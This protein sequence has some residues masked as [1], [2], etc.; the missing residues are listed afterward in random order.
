MI[1][2][3]KT[4]NLLCAC[5]C[6]SMSMRVYAF[7]NNRIGKFIE[8]VVAYLL[9]HFVGSLIVAFCEIPSLV[10]NFI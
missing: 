5:M 4:L 2:I 10:A 8:F 9:G 3:L 1:I 7:E 6:V